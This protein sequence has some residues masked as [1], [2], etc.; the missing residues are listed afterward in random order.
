MTIYV[1]MEVP[2]MDKK[3]AT[4]NI[5][6]LRGEKKMITP[7]KNIIEHGGLYTEPIPVS[8]AKTQFL[9]CYRLATQGYE[10]V[11]QKRS[12]EHVSIVST[13]MISAMLDALKFSIEETVEEG[14]DHPFTISV[15]EVPLYG[16]GTTR[17]AAIENLIDATIEYVEIYQEKMEVFNKVDSPQSKMYMLKLIRCGN[18]RDAIRKAYGL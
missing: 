6:S 17:E 16:T 7:Q 15:N 1:K 12:S 3:K 11:T 2:G 14:Y 5:K 10:V 13:S 8:K 4:K 9:E 18:D